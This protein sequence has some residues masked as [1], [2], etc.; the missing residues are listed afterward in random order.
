M[1]SRTL[2]IGPPASASGVI[3]PTQAPVLTPENRASVIT[4][5]SRPQERSFS[6]AVS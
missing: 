4:A 1:A 6:A 3:Q 2:L 5:T